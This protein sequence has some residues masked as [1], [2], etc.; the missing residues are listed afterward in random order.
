MIVCH[1][2]GITDRQIRH[3]VR[4]G[5]RNRSDVGLHC[6]AGVHCGGCSPMIDQIIDTEVSQ[7]E[8]PGLLTLQ[9]AAVG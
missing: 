4:S 8:V 7:F 2:K 5:A 3:A 6:T 1:C 9:E